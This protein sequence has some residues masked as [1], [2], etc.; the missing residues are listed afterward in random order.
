MGHIM[1]SFYQN[2]VKNK[3]DI[4]FIEKL[5]G[6]KV[7]DFQ[8]LLKEEGDF[9]LLLKS[10]SGC[11]VDKM[12]K[13]SRKLFSKYLVMHHFQSLSNLSMSDLSYLSRLVGIYF[14]KNKKDDILLKTNFSQE[15]NDQSGRI[16]LACYI[17]YRKD[18]GKITGH[19]E[20]S[21]ISYI[22][23]CFYSNSKTKNI[24]DNLNDIITKLTILKRDLSFDKFFS[25]K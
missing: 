17:L 13:L 5:T 21:A 24:A 2:L 19:N 23:N 1:D 4:K 16:H 25:L 20:R 22:K 14:S 15:K 7:C 18:Y 10:I 3:N 11:R 6:K 12:P 9:D 8:E